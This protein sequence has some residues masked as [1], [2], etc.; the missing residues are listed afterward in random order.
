MNVL[1]FLKQSGIKLASEGMGE[2]TSIY[3]PQPGLSP[4]TTGGGVTDIDQLPKKNAVLPL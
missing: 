2:S 4:E 1:A 3:S